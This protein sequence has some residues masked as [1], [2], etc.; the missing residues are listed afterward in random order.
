MLYGGKL[1][2]LKDIK[3]DSLYEVLLAVTGSWEGHNAGSFKID[4]LDIVRMKNNFDD[5]KVEIVVDYEHQ[6]LY[7]CEAPAAGWISDVYTS[8]DNTELWGK[9]KWTK[10]AYEYIKN[11]EYRYLSPVFNFYA[12]DQK[13]GANI[14]V[15]LESVALTNT[16]FLDELGEVRVNKILDIKEKEVEREKQ[17]AANSDEL[18]ALKTKNEEL[19]KQNEELKNLVAS[20]QVESAIV[21]NKITAEQKEWALSYAKKDLDGFNLFINSIKPA[22]KPQVQN[23]IF[24]NKVASQNEIDVV[25]FALGE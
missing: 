15:R 20:T 24:A 11:G 22:V 19:V 7:G 21:A 10:K 2:A 16:P 12:L 5:R 3:E 8:K 6:S 23:D 9:I 14:G 1:I 4:T 25:K 13:S 17:V 18:V